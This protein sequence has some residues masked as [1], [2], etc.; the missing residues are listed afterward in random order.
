MAD[1]ASPELRLIGGFDVIVAGRPLVL[2]PTAQRLLA[3]LALRARTQTRSWLAGTLWPDKPDVRA[4]ANLRAAMWRL[5]AALHRHVLSKPGQLGLAESWVVDTEQA[6]RLADQL[7][8]GETPSAAQTVVFCADL[9][10]LWDEPWLHVDRERYRQLR[11]H[12]LDQ[13]ARNQLAAG[14]PDLSVALALEALAVEP[15]RETAALL[16]LQAHLAQGNR[17]A[18]V[19]HFRGFSQLLEAELHVRPGPAMC[20]LV[21][22]VLGVGRINGVVTPM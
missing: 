2:P 10:P 20:N 1:T 13:L 9:L 14:R 5:P 16:V 17:A 6:A 3:L 19:D 11:L 22:S 8:E 7:H 4:F 21:D 18:A 15:L 12:A